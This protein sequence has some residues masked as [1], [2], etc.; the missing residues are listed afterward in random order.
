[1]CCADVGTMQVWWN[2]SPYYDANIYLGRRGVRVHNRISMPIGSM[3]LLLIRAG[4]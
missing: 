2:N 4:T 3:R 1:M